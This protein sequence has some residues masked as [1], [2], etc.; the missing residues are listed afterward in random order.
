MWTNR[1]TYKKIH[2]SQPHIGAKYELMI[3]YDTTPSNSWHII[4]VGPHKAVEY[5]CNSI[6]YQEHKFQKTRFCIL[7]NYLTASPGITCAEISFVALGES[8]KIKPKQRI[9]L[10]IENRD[11]ELCK[12]THIEGVDYVALYSND[13]NET[14]L[15]IY[16]AS[17]VKGGYYV[18]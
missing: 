6:T 5:F 10:K 3:E 12:I 8:T 11:Y 18:N 9:F 17:E 14:N 7:S 13:P 1:Y 16:P 4:I 15:L 2:L